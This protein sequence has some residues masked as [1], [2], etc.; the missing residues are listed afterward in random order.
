VTNRKF[1][2]TQV[3][4]T[5]LSEEPLSLR[6]HGQL[7]LEDIAVAIT[8]GDFSGVTEITEE[9]ELNGE[10]AAAALLEQGSDPELFQRN[11]WRAGRTGKWPRKWPK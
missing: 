2:K 8:E 3:L 6:P 11:P 5:V 1:Y 10:E 7:T 4:V 9:K